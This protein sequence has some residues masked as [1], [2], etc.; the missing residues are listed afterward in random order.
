MS[1]RHMTYVACNGCGC[2]AGGTDDMCDSGRE[3]RAQAKHLGFV[4]RTNG[5]GKSIDLCPS[6]QADAVPR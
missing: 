2:P 3:A 1:L 6:C 4:R 5:N